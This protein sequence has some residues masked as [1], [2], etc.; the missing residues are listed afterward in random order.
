MSYSNILQK[1]HLLE[2][3]KKLL[4][5]NIYDNFALYVNFDIVIIPF[6]FYIPLSL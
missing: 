6:L 4:Y 1:Y 2:I 3:I 5:S